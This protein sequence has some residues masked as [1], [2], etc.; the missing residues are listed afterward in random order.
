MNRFD[1]FIRRL[2]LVPP[3]FIG[4]TLLCFA[5][6]QFVPGGPVEQALMRMRGG[7]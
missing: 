7:G 6:I 4:I 1:Y 5:V 2:L 3:T